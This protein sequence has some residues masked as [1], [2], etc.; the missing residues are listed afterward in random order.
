MAG[1][2]GRFYVRGKKSI[3]WYRIGTQRISTGLEYSGQNKVLAQEKIQNVELNRVESKKDF[4][5]I[6]AYNYFLEQT[7]RNK[8]KGT[9][10]LYE[11]SI[12]QLITTNNYI[13]NYVAI[14]QEIAINLAK[15]NT[16]AQTK[17]TRLSKVRSF[18]QYFV[19]YEFIEKNPI[20]KK[21]FLKTVE[22]P[23]EIYE[24]EELKAIFD[25]LGRK[26][27]NTQLYF[28]ILYFC[29]FRRKELAQ[30]TWEQVVDEKGNFRE[31]IIIPLSKFK[32]KIDK[33]PLTK[34]L[35][36]YFNQLGVKTSGKIFEASE[37]WYYL[38]F[39]E[40]LDMTG[41]K[42]KTEWKGNTIGLHT[43]RKTRISEWLFKEKMPVQIVAELSRDRIQTIMQFYAKLSSGK[44]H[45]Y[46][47]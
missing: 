1:C 21:M 9:L 46:L 31:N 35:M 4:T 8:A 18:F 43:L 23:I 22:K 24:E 10:R 45:D 2:E 26:K 36:G 39:R 19:D 47:K 3:I 38:I 30:M 20:T 7:A 11:L 33:F 5:I 40:A 27:L 13:S 6:E 25:Y 32:N 17:N 37:D 44:L 41:I 29:A 12:R 42:A 15:L 16:L 34:E 28:K 14:R